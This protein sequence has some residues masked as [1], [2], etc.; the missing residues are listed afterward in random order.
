MTVDLRVCS[1]HKAP[2][3]CSK[4]TSSNVKSLIALAEVH[5]LGIAVANCISKDVDDAMLE[6][7]SPNVSNTGN[8][9]STICMQAGELQTKD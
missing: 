3:C 8:I 9:C 1:E 5:S 4:F 2:S 6:E 7:P